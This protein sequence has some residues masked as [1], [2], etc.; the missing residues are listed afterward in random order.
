MYVIGDCS[1]AI[2]SGLAQGAMAHARFV[3][4]DIVLSSKSTRRVYFEPPQFSHIVPIGHGFAID[5]INGKY[6]FSG[7]LAWLLRACI[8]LW[9]Y[10]QMMGLW[11]GV[12]TF[13]RRK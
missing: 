2:G 4:Q 7:Y 10:I 6:V 8:D 5:S 3:V 13:F 9:C 11:Q 1:S 12:R